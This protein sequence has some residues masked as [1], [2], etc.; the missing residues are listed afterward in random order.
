MPLVPARFT[1]PPET[2][3][4]PPKTRSSTMSF[5]L[6]PA[7]FPPQILPKT[8]KSKKQ[9]NLE[10]A[11]FLKFALERNRHPSPEDTKHLA[12]IC[13]V[14]YVQITDWFRYHGS[15][16][17][18]PA[19]SKR[20]RPPAPKTF[21]EMKERLGRSAREAL[22][23]AHPLLKKLNLAPTEHHGDTPPESSTRAV[24][25]G[26]PED[27][28]SPGSCSDERVELTDHGL[29]GTA[30][31]QPPISVE[32]HTPVA[33]SDN[34]LNHP[35]TSV[36]AYPAVYQSSQLTSDPL[37]VPPHAWLRRAN[38]REPIDTTA[39]AVADT[40]SGFDRMDIDEPSEKMKKSRKKFNSSEKMK[41]SRKKFNSVRSRN[42]SSLHADMSCRITC[43]C[44]SSRSKTIGSQSPTT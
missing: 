10:Y 17:D 11:P 8:R 36:H 19:K 32:E 16:Q 27:A 29:L 22:R 24:S 35:E 6:V 15:R 18:T 20:V 34:P 9:M 42:G 2:E 26:V 1:P 21:E 43:L 38:T 14:S 4:I 12:E 23:K 37:V 39:E 7:R 28:P 40:P 5:K 31:H 41:K 13:G 33:H 3:E 25:P 44:L 30:V